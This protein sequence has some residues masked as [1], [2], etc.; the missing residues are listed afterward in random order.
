MFHRARPHLALV[1]DE[2][3]TILGIVTPTDVLEPSP[4]SSLAVQNRRRRSSCART[5]HGWSMRKSSCKSW[6]DP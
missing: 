5:A 1:V 4:A 2:Y 6:S 3:G